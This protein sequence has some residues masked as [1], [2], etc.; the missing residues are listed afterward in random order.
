[1]TGKFD[2]A[3]EHHP[4]NG[5]QDEHQR[6]QGEEPVV[7]HQRREIA[8]LVVTELLHHRVGERDPRPAL[9]CPV[10]TMQDPLNE[11]HDASS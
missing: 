7:R 9:M 11:V 2:V 6:E 8:C 4:Q 3:L 10:R 5:D 1:M